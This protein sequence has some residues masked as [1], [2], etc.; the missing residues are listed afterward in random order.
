MRAVFLFPALLLA[1]CQSAMI[2]YAEKPG[3]TAASKQQD[4]D[5][6]RIYSMKSVPTDQQI[7]TIPGYSNPGTTYCNTIG[8][9]TTC[10]TV[11]AVN[12]PSTVKSYDANTDLR[13]REYER[14]ML[15]KGYTITRMPL[16]QTKDK[17]NYY[18]KKGVKCASGPLVR[19]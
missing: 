10:N 6:C 15:A 1:G 17:Q 19:W 18:N 5:T 13:N 14:C 7:R 8:G 11:G 12:I 4:S 2:N 9:V 16:C 3:M